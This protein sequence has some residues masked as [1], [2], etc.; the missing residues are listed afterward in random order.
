MLSCK[1]SVTIDIAVVRANNL[2]GF[3]VDNVSQLGVRL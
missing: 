2:S 3:A 1:L